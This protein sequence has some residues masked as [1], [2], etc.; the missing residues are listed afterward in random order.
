MNNLYH[1]VGDLEIIPTRTSYFIFL[2]LCRN[3]KT[4]IWFRFRRDEHY[5]EEII[6]LKYEK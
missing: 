4:K 5:K 1:N 3:D 6:T 2:F